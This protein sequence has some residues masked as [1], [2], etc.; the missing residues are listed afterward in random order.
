MTGSTRS[1]EHVGHDSSRDA[2]DPVIELR[3]SLF[4]QPLGRLSGCMRITRSCRTPYSGLRELDLVD[5]T[6]LDNSDRDAGIALRVSDDLPV[7]ANSVIRPPSVAASVVASPAA[8]DARKAEG[9]GKIARAI[10]AKDAANG[11]QAFQAP[12][13]AGRR[14][15]EDLRMA[16]GT[17]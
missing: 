17:A 2:D 16:G 13:D 12:E 8:R 9:A 11:E 1:P 7:R 15:A 5:A 14:L 3:F 6:D 10:G 4:E